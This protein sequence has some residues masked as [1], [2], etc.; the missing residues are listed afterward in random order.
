[1]VPPEDGPVEHGL[2]VAVGDGREDRHA[3]PAADL[4]RHVEEP[5]YE[6]ATNLDP[7]GW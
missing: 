7:S 3:E 4:L 1:M 5:G 2:G 6:L